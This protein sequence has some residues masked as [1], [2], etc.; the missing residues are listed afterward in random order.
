MPWNPGRTGARPTGVSRDAG[1][2]AA[3]GRRFLPGKGDR[4]ADAERG[5]REVGVTG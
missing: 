4:E 5:P 2:P 3:R 1:R